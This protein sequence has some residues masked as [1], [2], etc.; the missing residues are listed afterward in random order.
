MEFFKRGIPKASCARKQRRGVSHS[1]YEQERLETSADQFDRTA[2]IM[3]FLLVVVVDN[4]Q[5]EEEFMF[6]DITRCNTFAHL[7]ESG[8]SPMTER[9][10]RQAN[11]TAYCIP[12]YG[13]KGT[14]T[15]D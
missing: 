10:R 12:K 13:R 14:K 3:M 7:I 15:W 5:I 1:A 2:V 8:K 6:R 9:H 11:I 4:A